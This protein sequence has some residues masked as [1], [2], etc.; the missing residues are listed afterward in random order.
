MDREGTF[1]RIGGRD[2]YFR[3]LLF[4]LIRRFDGIYFYSLVFLDLKFFNIFLFLEYVI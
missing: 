4:F 2:R 1:F 3:K